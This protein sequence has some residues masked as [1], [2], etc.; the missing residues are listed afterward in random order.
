M[1][2]KKAIVA[3]HICLDVS[4]DLSTVPEGQFKAL[5]LPGKMIQTGGITVSTGGAVPNTGLALHT[6]GVPVRLIGKIGDDLFGRA[7]QDILQKKSPQLVNDLVIDLSMPTAFTIILNPPGFDRT[8]L[9]SHGANDAFYAS[10]LPRETLKNADLFHFGYPSLMRSIYRGD[11][12]ELVS[13]LMRARRAGLTTC[14]D[15]SLPD[16]TSPGGKADWPEILA[17]SLPYVDLFVPSVEELIF[18]LRREIYEQILEDPT[19]SFADAVTPDLLSELSTIVLDYGV[20]ALLIKLGHRGIYLRTG[21]SVVWKKGGRGLEGLDNAWHDRTW[22]MPAFKV[23]VRG[24]SGAGDAAIAGFLASLLQATD[25]VTALIMASAAGACSVETA[26]ACSGLHTWE[27]ILAR[28]QAGWETLPLDLHTDG[29]QKDE[30]NDLW[31][32]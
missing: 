3:G 17:N 25:P 23:K 24:T 30:A 11:G 15:F 31:Y 10:D 6:L 12:G 4:P 7:I 18:L 16:P 27:N 22:W 13:I 8:F 5:L 29:F 20:K 21:K 1:I 9:H 2:S 32:K 14:V 19:T 26:D 28:V